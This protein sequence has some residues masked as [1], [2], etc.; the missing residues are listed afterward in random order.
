MIYLPGMDTILYFHPPQITSAPDKLAGVQSAAIEA[1]WHVQTIECDPASPKARTLI[2]FWNPVGLIVESGSSDFDISNNNVSGCPMVYLDHDPQTLPPDT[3]CVYQDSAATGRMA[4]KELMSTG[5]RSFAYVPYFTQRFWC[6]DRKRGFR[7]AL[8]LNGLDCTV[9]DCGTARSKGIA[10]QNKM[11]GWLQKLSKPCGIFAAND[12]IGEEI[13]T[14]AAYTGI[15]V[16][17]E[18]A[19]VGVDDYAPI[20]E[21]AVT[22]LTSIKPDFRKGGELAVLALRELVNGKKSAVRTTFG[23]VGIVRR[24]SSRVFR[25][26]DRQVSDAVEMIRRKACEGMSSREVFSLFS[27]SRRMAEK[28]FRKVVGHSVLDEIQSVRIARACEL[29]ANPQLTL[30]ALANFC[31]YHSV[32]ALRKVFRAATGKTLHEWRVGVQACWQVS[33]SE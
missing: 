17:Q 28:R 23:P 16:P 13:L 18:I 8:A 31:G 6:E 20:C 25:I 5:F 9:F 15:A 3:S 29:L 33:Q 11:R 32:N 10:Y 21:H 14:A 7:E 22:P 30:E 12:H 2:E 26:Y 24:A 19:V 4:A 27:C 1:N